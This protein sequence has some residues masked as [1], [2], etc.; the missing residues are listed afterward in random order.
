MHQIVYYSVTAILKETN[1]RATVA[2]ERALILGTDV[3][4]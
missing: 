3:F 2:N 1:E 4:F